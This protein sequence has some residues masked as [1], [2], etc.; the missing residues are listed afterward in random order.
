MS[1]EVAADFSIQN[2]LFLFLSP[3][4]THPHLLLILGGSKDGA[5]EGVDTGGHGIEDEKGNGVLDIGREQDLILDLGIDQSGSV[6][7]DQNH[8]D[9]VG[10]H[11]G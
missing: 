5:A 4:T 9:H 7:K 1:D 6:I 10:G 11:T 8:K 3:T 2:A